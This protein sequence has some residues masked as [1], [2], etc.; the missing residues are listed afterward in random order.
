MAGQVDSLNVA[1]AASV[2]L[3]EA[4]RQRCQGRT[5]GTLPGDAVLH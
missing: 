5:A 1:Q 3:F 2:L 4:V